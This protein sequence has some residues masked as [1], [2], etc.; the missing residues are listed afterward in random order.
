[1]ERQKVTNVLLATIA[2]QL[3]F[4]IFLIMIPPKP[5]ISV[6]GFIIA[7]RSYVAL[8][9]RN[10][11]GES[12][13][14]ASGI[15]FNGKFVLSCTHIFG[16]GERVFSEGE[17]LRLI[18]LDRK[19]DLALFKSNAAED[20]AP[21][22]TV[23]QSVSRG[24]EVFD[25]SNANG[26]N[27]TVNFYLVKY[28]NGEILHFDKPVIPGESGAG[29][30]NSEGKLVGVCAADRGVNFITQPDDFVNYGLAIG[31]RTL[32]KFLTGVRDKDF[33][34]Y[35]TQAVVQNWFDRIMW[36]FYPLI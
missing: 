5:V 17:R 36:R 23:A 8:E 1:M 25:C 16:D 27:G 10:K 30:F 12:T 33:D 14:I 18:S 15:K 3:S 35:Y 2:A 13:A 19:H 22:V 9:S 31:P 26:N 7:Q 4:V 11:Q 20:S 21:L 32:A 28:S 6:K 29:V 24:E 34:N